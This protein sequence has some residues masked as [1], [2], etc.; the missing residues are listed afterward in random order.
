[1]CG[2]EKFGLGATDEIR[3]E[4]ARE[5]FRGRSSTLRLRARGK[6]NVLDRS[7]PG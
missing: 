6:G 5:A 2:E 3:A 4:E 1:M 7:P